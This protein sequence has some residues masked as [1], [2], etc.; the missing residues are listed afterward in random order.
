MNICRYQS[1]HIGPQPK[2]LIFKFS[3]AVVDVIC[4][5]LVLPGDVI[6]VNSDGNKMVDIIS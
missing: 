3:A 1:D 6:N 4:H 5:A 2:Q